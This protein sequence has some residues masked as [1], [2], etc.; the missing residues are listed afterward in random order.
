MLDYDEI[1]RVYR[2]EKATTKLVEVPED[3]Y[4]ALNE[5]IQKEKKS[6]L[7][8]LK[9]LEH[10]KGKDFANLRKMVEEWFGVRQKKLLSLA[11]LSCRTGE[12]SEERMA[13][14]E[15]ELYRSLCQSISKHQQLCEQLFNH[16]SPKTSSGKELAS[17]QVKVLKETP[18]FVGTDLKEYGPFKEGEKIQLPYKVAKLLLSKQVVELEEMD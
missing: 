15:K 13:L 3:F 7:D 14:P 4:N 12:Q 8:S 9:D 10:G 2:L 6:Y 11:L 17:L 16:D 1:L 5:F 18:S